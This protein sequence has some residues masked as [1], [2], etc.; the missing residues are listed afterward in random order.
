MKKLFLLL[1]PVI[2]FSCNN[3]ESSSASTDLSN[4]NFNW[5][6]A[7]WQ[8]INEQEDRETFESWSKKDNSEYHGIGYTLKN[9]DTIWKETM[10]LVESNKTWSLEITGKG[11]SKP[12]VFKLT[13][14]EKVQ[15]TSENPDNEFPKLIRYSRQGDKLKAVISGGDMEIPFEFKKV[16]LPEK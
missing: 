7:D 11:E 4:P 16:T 10:K 3:A 15:F 1:L 8:R 14:I 5:L 9:S 13:N 12:T 6:L 2:I